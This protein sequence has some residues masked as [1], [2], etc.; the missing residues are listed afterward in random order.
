MMESQR[1]NVE[2]DKLIEDGIK[3]RVTEI[4]KQNQN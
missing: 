4:I 2:I 1:S 3:T